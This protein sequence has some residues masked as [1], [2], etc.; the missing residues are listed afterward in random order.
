ML[1]AK[2]HKTQRY[3]PTFSYLTTCAQCISNG[4]ILS[5]KFLL[6]LCVSLYSDHLESFL[7]WITTIEVLLIVS[8]PSIPVCGWQSHIYINSVV[9]RPSHLPKEQMKWFCTILEKVLRGTHLVLILLSPR[10]PL[11]VWGQLLHLFHLA[12]SPL[13]I[14][15]TLRKAAFLSWVLSSPTSQ[16]LCLRLCLDLISLHHFHFWLTPFCA[17][18]SHE[19]TKFP[20]V[21]DALLAYDLSRDVTG[22]MVTFQ[23]RSSGQ[24]TY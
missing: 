1:T 17:L 3:F 15:A 20:C 23:W 19:V 11:A 4:D 2:H 7:S 8:F 5:S 22:G 18:G 24:T 16:T 14:P 9:I 21:I 12:C 6:N 13:S 10:I